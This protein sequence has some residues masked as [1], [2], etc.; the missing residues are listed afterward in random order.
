MI[1]DADLEKLNS[2]EPVQYLKHDTVA[3]EDGIALSMS[4]GGY[5]AMLFHLG[6]FWRLY[7]LGLL[8]RLDRISSVS[9]GSITAAMLGLVWDKI[10]AVANYDR[11][12]FETNVVRPI[13][14]LADETI[15]ASAVIGGIFL[16]GTISD[17]IQS[18]YKK[19]LYGDAT[20]QSLPAKPRFVINASNV[21]SGAL[22]RFSKPYM[23]DYRV[24]EVKNPTVSLAQAVGA[25]SAFPPVLSPIDRK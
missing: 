3:P 1:E 8:S 21:Q 25:S 24:G 14:L 23:R 17:K 6:A 10:Q 19:H 20:L 11:A 5:R 9:G 16:P 2:K 7:E 13:R 15:D 4:G 22:W 12:V 18:S